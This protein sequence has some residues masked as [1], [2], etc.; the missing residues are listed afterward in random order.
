MNSFDFTTASPL[1]SWW[2]KSTIKIENAKAAHLPKVYTAS[3]VDMADFWKRLRAEFD[4]KIAIISTWIDMIGVVPDDSSNAEEFWRIDMREVECCDYLIVYGEEGK[5]LRGAL[6]EVGAAIA[7][8][9][10]VIC[11][12]S[13]P[14][15]GTWQYHP[16]VI[17][18]N[19][20]YGATTYIHETWDAY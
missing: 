6:V 7:G 19:T 1:E 8:G 3:K 4:G 16:S 14:D 15:Y 20:I 13:H 9:K 2:G 18:V 11:V 17:R 5:H 10:T 12:G